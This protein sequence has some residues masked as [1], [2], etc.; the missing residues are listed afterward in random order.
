MSGSSGYVLSENEAFRIDERRA[1]MKPFRA[2]ELLRVVQE[3]LKERGETN[4]G[5]S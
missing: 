2:R 5:R 1:V 4:Q 3:A